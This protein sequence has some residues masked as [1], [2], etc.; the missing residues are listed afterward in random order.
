MPNKMKTKLGQVIVI[1]MLVC[2]QSS[3]PSCEALLRPCISPCEQAC[4]R[5]CRESTCCCEPA[6]CCPKGLTENRGLNNPT[7]ELP[8]FAAAPGQQKMDE[9]SPT[10]VDTDSL[11]RATTNSPASSS[12]SDVASPQ[13]LQHALVQQSMH[14]SRSNTQRKVLNSPE[15]FPELN[16][17]LPQMKEGEITGL[18]K[19]VAEAIAIVQNIAKSKPEDKQK[20]IGEFEKLL[21]S[22]IQVLNSEHGASVNL[23]KLKKPETL[24]GLLEALLSK[25]DHEAREECLKAHPQFADLV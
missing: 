21:T 1:A 6:C 5:P 23:L 7:L 10:T 15:A 20:L 17:I 25:M 16:H 2:V 11:N 13:P 12:A 22:K 19:A 14:A 3:S 18:A 4:S 9:T 24:R 8:L